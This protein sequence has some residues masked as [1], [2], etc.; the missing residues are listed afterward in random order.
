MKIGSCVGIEA[1]GKLHQQNAGFTIF[2]GEGLT[3]TLVYEGNSPSVHNYVRN[4]A[5]QME[6][7]AHVTKKLF[8]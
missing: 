7:T 1:M 2:Y 6:N 5:Y 8:N 3:A 4:A